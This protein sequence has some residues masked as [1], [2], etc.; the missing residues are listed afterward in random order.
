MN[1]NYYNLYS[2]GSRGLTDADFTNKDI[3]VDA[4]DSLDFEFID[5]SN[6][7]EMLNFAKINNADLVLQIGTLVNKVYSYN[8][9]QM[10]MVFIC[11]DCGTKEV[12]GTNEIDEDGAGF[13]FGVGTQY[14]GGMSYSAEKLICYNC[15]SAGLCSNCNEYVGVENIDK[16]EMECKWCLE[17]S[18]NE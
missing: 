15:Y 2:S 17:Q 8:Y 6:E 9:N 14:N 16:N 12:I 5:L 13:A 18:E 4:V 3:L 11:E 1:G 10:P 7:F